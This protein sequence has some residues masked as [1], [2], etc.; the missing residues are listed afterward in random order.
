MPRDACG[1]RSRQRGDTDTLHPLNAWDETLADLYANSGLAFD[2]RVRTGQAPPDET[3]GA[4][5][6]QVTGAADQRA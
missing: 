1:H 3:A 2:C 5:D 6:E 4:Y